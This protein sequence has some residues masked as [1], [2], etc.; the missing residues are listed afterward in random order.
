MALAH[1]KSRSAFTL[2]ELLVVIAIIAVLI[3]LLLPAVQKVRE[4]ANRSSCTNNLKQIGIA[5]QA[6]HGAFEAFPTGAATGGG[7]VNPAYGWAVFILPF[8]EQDNLYNRLSPNTKPL[9]TVF[10]TDLAALQIPVKTFICPSDQ[11]S[12]SNPNGTLN[13]NRPFAKE[14][15]AKIAI[16]NYPGNGGNSGG[17][18]I[19][20]ANSLVRIKDVSDGLSNTFL[21]GERDSSNSRYA[22]VWAGESTEATIVGITALVGY[23]EYQMQTGNSGSGAQPSQAFGSSHSGG[24]NFLLCDG[25]VRFVPDSISWGDTLGG[26]AASTYN[27]LATRAGGEVIPSY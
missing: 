19:F 8:V 18:G 21:A 24:A 22:A 11:G 25:S 20:A 13:G 16:S 23:T 15:N 14:G 26:A 9:A 7:S 1:R 12:P 27:A 2:I 6:Y 5:V 4:A 10:S 3:G 17:D